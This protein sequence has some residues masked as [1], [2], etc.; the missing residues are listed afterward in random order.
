MNFTDLTG[1]RE[2]GVEERETNASLLAN[3]RSNAKTRAAATVADI[4]LIATDPNEMSHAYEPLKAGA[5]GGTD[6]LDCVRALGRRWR[7]NFDAILIEIERLRAGKPTAIRLLSAT[8]AFV[9]DA[10]L[11]EGMPADFATTTGA[12]IFEQLTNAACGAASAR[13]AVCVDVRPILNGPTLDKP[14]DENFAQTVQAEANALLATDLPE[15]K[16]TRG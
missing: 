15:I 4:I 8:N 9:S 13:S 1:S 7:R 5:C 14:V 6:G 12:M 16:A 10:E 11:I 2:P 3:L